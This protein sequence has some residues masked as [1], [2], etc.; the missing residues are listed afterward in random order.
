MAV[1]LH[2]PVEGKAAGEL[3]SGD[4]EDWLV[5]QG[6]A[7]RENSHTDKHLITDVDAKDDPT[8]AANREK[9]SEGPPTTENPTTAFEKGITSIQDMTPA[10]EGEPTAGSGTGRVA[11][12]AEPGYDNAAHASDNENDVDPSKVK[13]LK[14]ADAPEDVNDDQGAE[15]RRAAEIKDKGQAAADAGAT[16]TLSV[17]EQYAEADKQAQPGRPEAA[18]SD[19]DEAPEGYQADPTE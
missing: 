8:L 18:T 1:R 5:A 13:A 19:E 11:K 2:Q 15:K 14:I 6:Y 3:Y 7:S 4:R 16:S 12:G 17:G 10:K 9:P